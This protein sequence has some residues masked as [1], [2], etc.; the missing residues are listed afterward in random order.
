MKSPLLLALIIG[1]VLAVVIAA[2]VLMPEEEKDPP[3]VDTI[4]Y[5]VSAEDMWADIYGDHVLHQT[6]K[7]TITLDH[8]PVESLDL[9]FVEMKG[10]EVTAKWS[11]T[12]SDLTHY[13]YN[14][15]YYP[16]SGWEEG[17][18]YDPGYPLEF[19]KSYPNLALEKA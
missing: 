19:A 16:V 10:S 15:H 6:T 8:L 7:Y 3:Q 13:K 1:A 18:V 17:R 9:Y 11:I 14:S 2:G 12:V 5:T 4:Y